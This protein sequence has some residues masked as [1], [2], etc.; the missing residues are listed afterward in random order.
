MKCEFASVAGPARGAR[1]A[2]LEQAP[3]HADAIWDCYLWPAGHD[4]LL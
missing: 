2:P 4:P 3:R 1:P